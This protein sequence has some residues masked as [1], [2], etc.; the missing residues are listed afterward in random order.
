MWVA[1]F[2]VQRTT[3]IQAV[4]ITKGR[5]ILPKLHLDPKQLEKAQGGR[6]SLPN[7]ADT[8]SI[9]NPNSKL[10]GKLAQSIL[11]PRSR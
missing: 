5:A 3:Q 2:G 11:S 4:K 9:E 10:F 6:H 1:W 7:K 8:L